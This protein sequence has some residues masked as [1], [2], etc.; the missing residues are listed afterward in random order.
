MRQPG[1]RLDYEHGAGSV[2]QLCTLR[3][4]K[5]EERHLSKG[6]HIMLGEARY[7]PEHAIGFGMALQMP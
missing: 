1:S 2:L 5:G 6:G 4:P 3:R 7:Q